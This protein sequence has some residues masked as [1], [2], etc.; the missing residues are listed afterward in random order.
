MTSSMR[1]SSPR[2]VDA[3]GRAPSPGRRRPRGPE[4]SRA[5]ARISDARA[6]PGMSIPRNAARRARR[7]VS[8]ARRAG[9]L[10]ARTSIVPRHSVPPQS[11]RMRRAARFEPVERRLGIGSPLEAVRGVR[12]HP[13]RARR[14]PDRARVEV[15]ALEE[16][17]RRLLRDRRRE[18][19]HDA[20][21]GDGL[22]GVRDH[23][24]LRGERAL[25]AV[26]RHERLPRPRAPHDDRREAVDSLRERV[27]VERV[28]RLADVPEDVIRRVD[29]GGDRARAD[30]ARAAPR[31]RRSS[32]P[33]RIPS[34]T[35]AEYR[36]QSARLLDEDAR[37]ACRRPCRSP[38]DGD[39]ASGSANARPSATA[40]SRARPRWFIPSGRFAVISTS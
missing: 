7:R 13:E 37:R 40:A 28:E 9:S 30:R 36:E 18:P 34:M 16:D 17:A 27:E 29:R 32:R 14:P 39:A 23:E 21:E 4:R 31:R 12:V 11:S 10:A 6:R 5:R 33:T 24:M 19:A 22:L 25:D 1:S 15:R 3:P 38:G 26:E 2:D 8:V 20:R 35:R